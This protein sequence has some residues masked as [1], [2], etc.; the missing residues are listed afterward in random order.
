MSTDSEPFEAN[1]CYQHYKGM[2]NTDCNLLHYLRLPK[3]D[4]VCK[5]YAKRGNCAKGAS[6]LYMHSNFPCKYYYLDLAHPPEYNKEHCLF[7]HGKSIG[8][9]MSEVLIEEAIRSKLL[10]GDA[11]SIEMRFTK[12]NAELAERENLSRDESLDAA[13]HVDEAVHS[14]T[15][16]IKQ[17]QADEV[18]H[19]KIDMELPD[20]LLKLHPILTKGQLHYLMENNIVS[21]SQIISMPV[22]QQRAYNLEIHQIYELHLAALKLGTITRLQSPVTNVKPAT[23]NDDESNSNEAEFFGFGNDDSSVSQEDDV[24]SCQEHQSSISNSKI[25]TNGTLTCYARS[26]KLFSTLISLILFLL[27]ILVDRDCSDEDDDDDGNVL[28]INETLDCE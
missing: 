28:I 26:F 18:V 2:C 12:R 7:S 4:N 22:S 5:F 20:E 6:C 9:Q 27:F 21:L 17:G 8:K 24:S 11:D 23:R 15:D 3:R 25:I 13:K 14:L 16:L 1:M 10:H 19:G